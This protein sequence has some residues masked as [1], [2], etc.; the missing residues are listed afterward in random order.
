MKE[1][2][3]M[4][5]TVDGPSGTGKSTI[6]QALCQKLGFNYLDSGALYRAIA[7]AIQAQGI[8][9]D[10]DAKIEQAL[11]GLDIQVQSHGANDTQ[12]TIN[13]EDLTTA[14]RQEAIGM[15]ASKLSA[16]PFLR[17]WLIQLQ[18][19]QAKPPGLV[20]DGRDMGT[21]VFPHAQIKI[22]LTADVKVRAER[23]FKQLKDQG[24]SVSL[25]EVEED[26]NIRDERD[27]TRSASPL[28]PAEDAIH[29]DTSSM[30]VDQVLAKVLTLCQKGLSI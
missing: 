26:L 1:S 29:M 30:S 3:I 18:R 15:L 7:Y 17:K 5:I 14:I 12:V 25:R 9:A 21:V 23:R 11:P 8:T 20:T 16:K 27:Q 22:Y 6:A 13:G 2:K 10:E 4:V 24:R 19:A 28:K